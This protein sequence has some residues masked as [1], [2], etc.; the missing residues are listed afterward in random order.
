MN[1]LRLFRGQ[2]KKYDNCLFVP[3]ALRGYLSI[4]YPLSNTSCCNDCLNI[5][6]VEKF[7]QDID[8]EI[9]LNTYKNE[10]KNISKLY[11][12]QDCDNGI[13]YIFWL[14]IVFCEYK[15]SHMGKNTSFSGTGYIPYPIN[16]GVDVTD[17]IERLKFK[18]DSACTITEYAKKISKY[19]FEHTPPAESDNF[20]KI[21][22][23]HQHY[24]EKS[25]GYDYSPK[26]Y[27]TRDGRTIDCNDLPNHFTLLLDWTKD[28]NIAKKFAGDDGTIVSIDAEKYDSL[29]GNGY[30]MSYNAEILKYFLIDTAELQKSV[31]T[32]WPWTFTIN[33]LEHNNLGKVLNFKRE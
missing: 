11:P 15:F 18:I 4:Q 16:M 29:L 5:L 3:S 23:D 1:S 27:K 19:Y 26:G 22:M 28:K 10:C 20:L 30:K 31:V 32:F 7:V 33:Q 6:K 17:D 24:Y 13:P 8:T 12:F 21:Y 25:V 14:S 2:N 9:D